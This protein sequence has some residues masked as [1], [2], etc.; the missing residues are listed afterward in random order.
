VADA[1]RDLAVIDDVLGRLWP[2]VL[3]D[4]EDAE[5]ELGHDLG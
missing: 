3:H 2:F 4:D 1:H 5:T